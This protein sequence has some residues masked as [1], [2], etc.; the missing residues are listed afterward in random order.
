M[1]SSLPMGAAG[2]GSF[3]LSSRG[4]L[5]VLTWPQFDGEGLE[6]VVTTRS[7]GV[8][9]G[10]YATL[11]LGLHVGDDPERVVEN[12]RRAAAAVGLG[13]PD[14][15]FC[16]QAHGREVA[17]V[18]HDHRGRGTESVEDA[19]QGADALVTGSPGIGL[20][21]MVADC[22]PIVLF[23]PAARVLSCI[24]AGWRG[25]VA[26]VVDV[27]LE[28]M[29]SL[30]AEP[31][32]VL[33]GIGPAIPAVRYQVGP[34]VAEAAH[35]GLGVLAGDVVRADGA[36]RWLFDLWEANRRMLLEAG[37]PARNIAVAAVGT[38]GGFPFFSDREVRPCGRFAAVAALHR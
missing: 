11:N 14:L 7:G 35:D 37:V 32:R 19:V 15:V 8:S 23:D 9:E 5:D 2:A 24:H 38:G 10:P 27:T 12:R 26:R 25:T 16:D 4:A 34:E 20:V 29:G 3:A 30:G 13:L 18:D 36:G 1:A 33:A 22:V 17:V 21:V 6:A 31:G 28:V